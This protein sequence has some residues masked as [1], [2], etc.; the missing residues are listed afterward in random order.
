MCFCQNPVLVAEYH[1]DCWHTLQWRL[2]SRISGATK[3]MSRK[4]FICN[5]YGITGYVKHRKYKNWRGDYV[6]DIY[7][8]A[9]LHYDPITEFCPRL[10]EVAYQMFTGLVFW[11]LTTRHTEGPCADFDDQYVKRR[12]FAQGCVFW[13]SRKLNF[14][15][16][17]HYRQKV[18]FS[19]FS[20]GIMIFMMK[21]SAQNGH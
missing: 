2:L 16:R 15:Y 13:G 6:P 18:D 21:I 14:T 9:K 4:K 1:V 12:R 3:T 20:T 19:R 10:C 7:H 11:V 5:Q 17:P 8:F